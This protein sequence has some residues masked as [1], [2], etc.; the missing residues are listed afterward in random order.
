[1][2]FLSKFEPL[3]SFSDQKID[4]LKG[5]L[6]GVTAVR[7]DLAAVAKDDAVF[8]AINNVVASYGAGDATRTNDDHYSCGGGYTSLDAGGRYT[9][10]IEEI[11]ALTEA[12][13][14]T[15]A[16]INKLISKRGIYPSSRILDPFN[17]VGVK[18]RRN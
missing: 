14:V 7:R 16:A 6:A 12:Q 15:E 9:Q 2:K 11:E 8:K 4:K 1:M 5:D 10:A 13:G 17:P 3:K 18:R